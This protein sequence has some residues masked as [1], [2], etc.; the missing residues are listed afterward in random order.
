MHRIG[1]VDSVLIQYLVQNGTADDKVWPLIQG[2]LDLLNKAGLSKDNF[3]DADTVI[4]KVSTF[5][6][7]S[8]NALL[9][10]VSDLVYNEF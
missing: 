2:K 8:I 7:V 1:Q 4:V 10:S 5:V 9:S 6:L 3:R